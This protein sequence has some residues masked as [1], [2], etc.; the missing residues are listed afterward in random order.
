MNT[1]TTIAKQL[2]LSQKRKKGVLMGPRHFTY[3]F[4]ISKPLAYPV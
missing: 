3:E 1:Q 4:K 2:N